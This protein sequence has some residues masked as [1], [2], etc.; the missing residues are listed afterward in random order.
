MSK[1]IWKNIPNYNGLYQ[2]SNLG[3]IKSFI[4]N[5]GSYREKILKTHAVSRYGHQALG[6]TKNKITRPYSVHRL[7]LET[8]VGPCPQGKECRH[9]DGN[10][11]NNRLKNLRWGT[12]SE[13]KQDS[14]KH[15]THY[16]PDNS[17]EKCGTS[18]LTKTDVIKIRDLLRE[19]NTTIGQIAKLFRISKSTIYKI[20]QNKRW[21]IHNK[22]E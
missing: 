13:N 19:N 20:K 5:H 6:L 11:Q 9:I 15:G 3:K 10:P 1:E 4:D 12:R 16:Q 8:F 18:K 7:V 14:M 21:N 22:K 2:V 17:G